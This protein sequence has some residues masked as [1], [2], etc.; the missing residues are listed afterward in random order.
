MKCGAT[1]F[2]HLACGVGKRDRSALGGGLSKR[3]GIQRPRNDVVSGVARFSAMG[4]LPCLGHGCSA[5]L[6]LAPTSE[7]CQKQEGPLRKNGARLC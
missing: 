4:T 3:R 7:T 6:T 1:S 2:S 5:A